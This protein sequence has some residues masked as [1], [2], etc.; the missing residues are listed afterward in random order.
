[1]V[2]ALGTYP[3]K[4]F[5]TAAQVETKIQVVG[6]LGSSVRSPFRQTDVEDTPRNN[7]KA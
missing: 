4:K 7:R 2:V 1:M 3:V 5:A 6:C